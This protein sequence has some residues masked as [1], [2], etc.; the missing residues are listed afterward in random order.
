[1]SVN[2]IKKKLCYYDIRKILC[3]GMIIFSVSLVNANSLHSK[4]TNKNSYTQTINNII[5][6]LLKSEDNNIFR[7]AW[8]LVQD[9]KNNNNFTVEI[10]VIKYSNQIISIFDVMNQRYC[11]C[12]IKYFP[13]NYIER[14]GKL[15]LWN[16]PNHIPTE[17]IINIMLNYNFIDFNNTTNNGYYLLDYYYEVKNGIVKKNRILTKNITIISTKSSFEYS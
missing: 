16:E 12:N 4:K 17:D 8:L 3:F 7:G 15:F 1:M 2:K 14:S 9:I 13:T 10:N 5:D 6:D 11:N